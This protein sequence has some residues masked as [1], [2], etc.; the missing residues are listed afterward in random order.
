MNV[1]REFEAKRKSW[2]PKQEHR[3]AR[4]SR[5]ENAFVEA[6]REEYDLFKI[7]LEVMTWKDYSITG[8]DRQKKVVKDLEEGEVLDTAL[9]E[10]GNEQA[11]LANKSDRVKTGT[12]DESERELDQLVDRLSRSKPKTVEERTPLWR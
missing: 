12:L 9:E 4:K 1:E 10:S 11:E 5:K 8:A 6:K 7:D 3:W 2:K